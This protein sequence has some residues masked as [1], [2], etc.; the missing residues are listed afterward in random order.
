MEG[1]DGWPCMAKQDHASMGVMVIVVKV[2]RG[3]GLEG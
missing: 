2:E 3:S 1:C